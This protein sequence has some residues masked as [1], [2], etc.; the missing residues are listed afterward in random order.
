MITEKAVR[1]HSKF[2]LLTGS[3][4]DGA[5]TSQNGGSIV[6]A[7]R[8]PPPADPRRLDTWV[9]KLASDAHRFPFDGPI[10]GGVTAV[11]QRW[12]RWASRCRR[13]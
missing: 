8:L 7:T 3:A 4:A 9:K 11:R 10:A 2:E 5:L 13:Q 6:V 12:T 1:L